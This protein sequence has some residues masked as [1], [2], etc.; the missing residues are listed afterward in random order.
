MGGSVY[1]EVRYDDF[2]TWTNMTN[3]MADL[4]WLELSVCRLKDRAFG[5]DS[6]KMQVLPL[7][8]TCFSR[9]GSLMQLV[10]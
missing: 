5:K 3:G 4:G 10:T 1:G 9:P 6:L 7:V 2:D 8:A